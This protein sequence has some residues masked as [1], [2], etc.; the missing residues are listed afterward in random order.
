MIIAYITFN[1]SILFR[2]LSV[3]VHTLSPQR[4]QQLILQQQEE[5]RVSSSPTTDCTPNLQSLNNG[6]I[7]MSWINVLWP[8]FTCPWSKVGTNNENRGPWHLGTAL[9]LSKRPWF[10]PVEHKQFYRNQHHKKE[11][12]TIWLW[13]IKTKT[14]QNSIICLNKNKNLNT[15]QTTKWPIYFPILTN[16]WLL[17]LSPVTV[18]PHS[19]FPSF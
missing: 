10:S 16:E 8:V 17:C 1:Q 2:T 14:R 12:V 3:T 9:V 11:H 4:V 13:W 5:E 6:K 18:W 15:V 19:S 7:W